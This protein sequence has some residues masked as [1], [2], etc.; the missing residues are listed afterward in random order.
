LVEFVP[1]RCKSVGELGLVEV[2]QRQLA[3][4]VYGALL[5]A[6]DFDLVVVDVHMCNASPLSPAH[7]CEDFR[8]AGVQCKSTLRS[9]VFEVPQDTLELS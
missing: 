9:F 5:G 6:E 1:P 2:V 7:I 3:T 4:Q 8:F